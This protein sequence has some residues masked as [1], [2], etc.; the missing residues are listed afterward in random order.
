LP[1]PWKNVL[2]DLEQRLLS[3]DSSPW[4]PPADLGPMPA[5]VA[6]HA[7]ALLARQRDAV[8][9]AAAELSRIGGELA[10]LR[11]PVATRSESRPAFLDIVA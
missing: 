10:A 9:A 6:P 4:T 2:D 5:A 8:A 11:R 1:D 7:H 3:G